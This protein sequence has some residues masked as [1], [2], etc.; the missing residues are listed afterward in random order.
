[1][2]ASVFYR[3]ANGSCL[4]TGS[5]FMDRSNGG[6][7]HPHVP[8]TP[9]LMV[10]GCLLA[11]TCTMLLASMLGARSLWLDELFS[12]SLASPRISLTDGLALIRSDV[13]PPLYFFALQG[14]LHL[15]GSDTEVAARSL[16]FLPCAFAAYVMLAY[17]NR[18]F[19]ALWFLLAFSSFG[20]WWFVQ[21]ARMYAFVIAQAITACVLVLDFE[22]RTVQ[23]VTPS[24]VAA[25]IL[26]YLLLPL[27][28]WFSVAFGGALLLGLF[29]L[30]LRRSWKVEATLYCSLGL[31][32]AVLGAIWIGFNLANTVGQIGTYGEHIYGGKVAPW[33]LRLSATGALLFALTLNP[34]LIVA[35]AAGVGI[36][37]IDRRNR[38]GQILI[39]GATAGLVCAILAASFVSPMYQARNF[40]WTTAPLTLFA[41]IGM[42]EFFLRLRTGAF[43]SIS[44]M[45]ASVA[46][47]ALLA[48]IAPR[49]YGDLPLDDWRGAGRFVSSQPFCSDAPINVSALFL[50][51]T[52]NHPLDTLKARFD[53]GYYVAY[54]NQFHPVGRGEAFTIDP[55]SLCNVKFWVAQLPP[56]EAVQLGE[57]LLGSQ[58]TDLK[59]VTFRGHTI[60]VGKRLKPTTKINSDFLRGL[61]PLAVGAMF[62]LEI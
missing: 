9:Q 37:L 47:S 18:Y 57:Q 28:H 26:S 33:G 35:A 54:P 41:A 55:K 17:S 22:Q 7:K 53:Y 58:M 11:L 36:I 23:V 3:I 12:V 43:A 29:F 48:L 4:E 46:M 61:G 13:H 52:T 56:D 32:L 60:F 45:A 51:E 25:A 34:I 49:L 10:F 39:L 2:T 30:S 1:L 20:L 62:C 14:W 40:A 21:E 6:M 19:S 15:L 38:P 59:I 50:G 24:R 27:A 44:V 16:N 42:A 31:I 5:V 8:G